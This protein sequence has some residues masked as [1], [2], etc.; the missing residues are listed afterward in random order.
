MN[1]GLHS[2]VGVQ[3]VCGVD[4]EGLG[5]KLEGDG[6]HVKSSFKDKG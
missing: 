3:Q 5:S 1:D 2:L 4:G 6:F